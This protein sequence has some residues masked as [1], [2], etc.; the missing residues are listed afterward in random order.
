MKFPAPKDPPLPSGAT[1]LAGEEK[2]DRATAADSVVENVGL[3]PQRHRI[4]RGVRLGRPLAWPMCISPPRCS[5]GW[6][7][8]ASAQDNVGASACNSVSLAWQHGGQ[9][10]Q[11]STS[12]VGR[13]TVEAG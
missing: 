13:A 10:Q 11:S 2:D 12:F 3:S 9:L 5:H 7:A 8:S 4:S 1:D 6:H